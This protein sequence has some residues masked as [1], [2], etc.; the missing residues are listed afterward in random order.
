MS[1]PQPDATYRHEPK[2]LDEARRAEGG[3]VAV[4][5]KHY[6]SEVGGFYRHPLEYAPDV[7][8]PKALPGQQD[9]SRKDGD[10]IDYD[11]QDIM[12]HRT[13]GKPEWGV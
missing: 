13:Y 8:P 2:W 6:G 12:Q 11:A 10:A 7:L 9:T 5:P 3:T 4:K 1:Y